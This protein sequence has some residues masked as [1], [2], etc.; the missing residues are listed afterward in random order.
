LGNAIPFTVVKTEPQGIVKVS[1]TTRLHVEGHPELSAAEREQMAEQLRLHRFAWLKEI[2]SQYAAE[3][4]KFSVPDGV[5]RDGE[6]PVLKEATKQAR[7]TS[8]PVTI[9][10]NL[11]TTRGK[12]GS[13]PWA[14]V[15]PNSAIEYT[16]ERTLAWRPPKS[17]FRDG[18]VRLFKEIEMSSP[19]YYRA[20]FG[21]SPITWYW[22]L[23]LEALLVV[24]LLTRNTWIG[25]VFLVVVGS[26][27]SLITYNRYFLWKRRFKPPS[28]KEIEERLSNDAKQILFRA[29]DG[30]G[31]SA[32]AIREL[33]LP[34][35]RY[36]T[37][38]R[39][40]M[41]LGL[42]ERRDTMY[43]LTD[44]GEDWFQKLNEQGHGSS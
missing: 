35:K 36:Y 9:V 19:A 17:R 28:A 8:Q 4:A 12:I 43:R 27:A 20:V 25:L 39:T 33:R 23:G 14:V 3:Y 16:Y 2:E 24:Y 13:F 30:I 31:K 11:W 37:A 38:L 42:I 22:I 26:L 34:Q 6:D 1:Q 5:E 21:L 7:E 10:V 41:E 40:L 44:V 29:K 32:D 15:Q 18:K